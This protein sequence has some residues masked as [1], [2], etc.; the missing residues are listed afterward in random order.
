MLLKW[1]HPIIWFDAP[2]DNGGGGAP[3]ADPNGGGKKPDDKPTPEPKFTQD[4]MDRVAGER[5][6]RAEEATQKKLLEL[7]GV[8]DADEAKKLLDDAKKRADA[9]KSD[10]DKANE[11]IANLTKATEAAD[12]ARKDAIE[13]ATVTLMRAAVLTEASKPEYR[14]KPDALADVWSFIDRTSIKPKD[15]ADGEF[16]GV[17]EALKSL[18][19]AKGYLTET[20]DGH[21][22]PRPGARGKSGKDDLGKDAQEQARRTTR[23][24]F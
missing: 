22:T 9:E 11:Q 23:N 13:K 19:K 3:G 16:V 2:S 17:A 8:K 7:L 14:F 21:G 12:Q 24:N 4:D 6:K 5:A 20:G 18:A 15:G 1:L 10:L